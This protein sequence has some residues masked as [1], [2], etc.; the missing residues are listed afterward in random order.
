MSGVLGG[1]ALEALATVVSRNR[2]PVAE[3]CADLATPKR[4][5]RLVKGTGI[6]KLSIVPD[7][8]YITDLCCMAAKKLFSTCDIKRDDIKVV[9]FVTQTPEYLA[10]G[11]G[12]LLQ[13]RLGLASNV[14]IIDLEMGCSGFVHGLIIAGTLLK[15][16]SDTT[17][18]AQIL[19][20]GGDISASVTYPYDTASKA[21]FGDAGFAA[22][23]GKN[24]KKQICYDVYSDGTRAKKLYL[25]WGGAHHH[26]MT[27]ADGKLTA[28]RQ[29]YSTMDGMAVM[30]F[31]LKEVPA[32]IQDLLEFAHL[33]AADVDMGF[34]HQANRLIV[35]TLAESLH[36]SPTKMPFL[37]EDI[38]NTSSA[39]VPVC[40]TEQKRIGDWAP[41]HTVLLSG[42]GIG[43][44]IASAVMDLSDTYVEGTLEI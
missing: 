26:R 13:G 21:L 31:T 14:Q 36:M 19:L 9:V 42:F 33:R 41:Y 11:T 22:I 20:C 37:S 4:L 12:F 39:S 43:L 6:E 44:T 10:P 15:G 29:N 28:D 16:M 25:P 23:I 35:S 7:N 27:N 3:W 40:M 24:E 30:D 34:V 8:T 38:G 2:V 32:K 5:Q 18:G 17:D 1:V